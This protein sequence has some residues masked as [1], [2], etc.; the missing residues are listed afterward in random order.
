MEQ[1]YQRQSILE[2]IVFK[3][4]NIILFFPVGLLKRRLMRK[5][6]KIFSHKNTSVTTR[7]WRTFRFGESVNTTE[8]NHVGR[9]G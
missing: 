2:M 8:Q 5:R 6:E 7:A 9:R 4:E 1:F 3:G